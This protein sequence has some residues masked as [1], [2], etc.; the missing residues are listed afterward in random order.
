ML[1]GAGLSRVWRHDRAHRFFSQARWSSQDL[2]LVL[3]KLIVSLLVPDGQPVL[4]AI[5]DT[6]FKR[7]GRK[8]H[9][10]GWFHDGSAKGPRQVG[11]GNNW[12]ICAI[13]VRLPFCSRPVALPVTARLV[14]KDI[15]PAPASRLVL[16][17]QMTAALA[18]ALP[19]RDI[20]VV[21][22][23]AYAG[24]ELA[25]LPATVTWTTRLRKDA[26]LHELPPPRTG[27]RGRPRVKGAR[28][29][30]L[31]AL[32][33]TASFTPVTVT[34]YRKTATVQAAAFTCLWHAVFGSRPVQVILV[35]DRSRGGYDLALVTTDPDASPAVVIE[36]YAARWSIEVAFEDAR[37]VFGAGQARNRTAR[38]VR[39]TVPFTLTCQTLAILWYATAGHDPA[40]VHEHR[41]RAPWY[42]TKAEPSTADMTAKLRRVLIAAKFRLPHPDQPTPAEI[43]AIRLAWETPAA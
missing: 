4:A 20:H 9:A 16:A 15:K 19:G 3:A 5:D 11:L 1:T 37:Q 38:A 7:T 40:D 26:A 31:A 12:V 6:L 27:R 39:A 21:A 43:S 28:L 35:R 10:I 29:P 24:K 8:V 36:R 14:H 32:A 42:A 33:E 17:R 22:D 23:A 30:A 2:G 18:R 41:A 34:R 13:V 25:R